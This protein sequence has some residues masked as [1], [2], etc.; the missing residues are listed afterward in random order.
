MY[1]SALDLYKLDNFKYPTTEQ[2]LEALV[3]K[4]SDPNLTNYR[5]EG[6][7]KQLAKDP[8]G[9]DY[10]YVSPGSN[11]APYDLYTLGADGQ[12]GGEGV[13]ADINTREIK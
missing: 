4:P 3:R 10:V 7:V 6:Y 8:W 1:E 2:G 13:D 5:P 12:V 9:R 11:G